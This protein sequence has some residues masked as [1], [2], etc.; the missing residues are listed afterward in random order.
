MVHNRAFDNDVPQSGVSKLETLLKKRGLA[1]EM[2][3]APSAERMK[4]SGLVYWKEQAKYFEAVVA[5]LQKH[6]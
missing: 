6:L 2:P 3:Y 5:F 4:K 1:Y